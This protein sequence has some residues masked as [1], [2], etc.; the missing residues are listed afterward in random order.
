[1]NRM[2]IEENREYGLDCTKAVWATD[3]V[4]TRFHNAGLHVLSDADFIIETGQGLV[5]IEY[6]NAN[7]SGAAMPN[8]FNPLD[9]KKVNSVI[10]KFYDTLHYLTLIQKNGPKRYVYI[11]EAPNGDAVMRKRLRE[12]L[13]KELP[14]QLQNDLN[15]GVKL[16]DGVDVLSISEWNDHPQ[17]SE[18]PLVKLP[19]Q[20]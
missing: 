15:T 18:Y 16:I 2:I 14:F 17:Y 6:K 1:M 13:T 5:I 19:Q 12:L 4:H 20:S 10:H 7:I 8:S 3:E 9:D 11:V